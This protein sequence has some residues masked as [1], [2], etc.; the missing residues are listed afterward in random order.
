MY[1]ISCLHTVDM[2]EVY[3]VAYSKD[4]PKWEFS[5]TMSVA[6]HEVQACVKVLGCPVP[7]QP[8]LPDYLTRVAKIRRENVKKQEK[9]YKPLIIM[10][11]LKCFSIND[12]GDRLE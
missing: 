8:T 12:A 1:S 2:T 5:R 4:S 9:A 3:L 7:T 11:S 6:S 10:G